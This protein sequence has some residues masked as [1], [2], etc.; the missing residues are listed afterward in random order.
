M[1]QLM[2]L[3]LLFPWCLHAQGVFLKVTDPGNPLVSFA[4]TAATYKGVAWIDL[5]DD[6]LP[7]I[8]V[9]QRFLFHNDGN[10]QFSQL[11]NVSGATTGQGAAGSSWGD[12]D[13]D[14]HPDCI[15]A[16]LISGVH[17]NNGDN[18]FSVLNTSLPNFSD[19]S[20]WDC[21][22]ADA[23]NNGR[24]DPLFVHA[25]GF[26]PSGPFSCRFYLQ[27]T[28]GSFNQI[29][30]YEFTDMLGAYTVPVWADYDLDGDMDLFI[31]SGPVANPP[32]PLPDFNYRNMLKENGTFSMQRLT[33]APF[34]SPQDG[35]TYNF[36]DV[37]ND[38]DLDVCLTN[39]ALAPTRFYRNNGGNYQSVTTPFT[40]TVG[41]LA[42]C[43]GDV[44]NDG[45][46]DVLTTEDGVAAVKYYKNNGDGT[47]TAAAT[48]GTA[49]S[50][51]CGIAFADYDNDG[52]LDFYTNG[53][54]EGRAFFRNTTLAGNRK[55]AQFTLQGSTSNRSAIGATLRLKAD[56]GGNTVWQIRQVTAHNS[57][58]SQNDLRQH[59]G[60]NEASAI[61]SLEVRWPS[62]LNEVFT[63]LAVNN[64]YKIVEGQGIN[65][66]TP[67]TEPKGVT[68]LEVKPNPVSR[69]FRVKAGE[70]ISA[71]E[72]YDSSGRVLPLQSTEIS[73][74]EWNIWLLG[75]PP[76]GAYYLRVL[77]E[78]GS[79]AS[80]QVMKF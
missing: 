59:F 7:D 62:G 17:H 68:A 32:G 48:A 20:A 70:K 9:S 25:N 10:G 75:N 12:M 47:F 65:I 5:D 6:N 74:G 55:W 60:L 27:D 69:E 61:D 37:E 24:L 38:G 80:H 45:Y 28:D 64:F 3:F 39:Y 71:V 16:S 8:F 49:G 41:H 33:G 19:Y 51:V 23:D 66:L 42:N 35:Q 77:F 52:D 18:T 31:G 46:L 26:H 43:W 53:P 14:G 58:Q 36:I 15:T 30:G 57:F 22:L 40:T 72:M 54:G 21:A 73:S 44:N 78:N 63:N 50:N 79:T 13:N 34:M 56:L 67:V 29:T 76:A 2:L 4:N 11:T 1:K